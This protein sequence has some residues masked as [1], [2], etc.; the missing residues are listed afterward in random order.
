[1]ICCI[2]LIPVEYSIFAIRCADP[3]IVSYRLVPDILNVWIGLSTIIPIQLDGEADSLDRFSIPK[4]AHNLQVSP[5]AGQVLLNLSLLLLSEVDG[6]EL[7]LNL[8]L[9][10]RDHVLDQG[11]SR[12]AVYLAI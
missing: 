10:E 3:R 8:F 5:I 9:R 4:L 7:S 12:F 6:E 11:C 1:M 2:L